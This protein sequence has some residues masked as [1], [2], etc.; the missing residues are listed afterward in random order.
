VNG[1]GFADLLLRQDVFLGRSRIDED[2]GRT[3]PLI[4]E[5]DAACVP[6]PK[7]RY[8]PSEILRCANM[9]Q[10]VA[11]GDVDADGYDD[12]V[13]YVDHDCVLFFRGSSQP[14]SP[15]KATKRICLE[16]LGRTPEIVRFGD[17]NGDG[18][19]DVGLSVGDGLGVFLSAPDGIPTRPSVVLPKAEAWASGGDFD[20]D[21]YDD[22]AAL[23]SDGRI[24]FFRGS[25]AGLSRDPAS[26]T[27]STDWQPVTDWTTPQIRL[28]DLDGDGLADLVGVRM[29]NARPV[30]WMISGVAA[31]TQPKRGASRAWP[32][33]DKNELNFRWDLFA[34]VGRSSDGVVMVV[35]RGMMAG[36]VNAAPFK[37]GMG[38]VLPTPPARFEDEVSTGRVPKAVGDVNGDG[39][40]DMFAIMTEDMDGSQDGQLF[41]GDASGISTRKGSYVWPYEGRARDG[42]TVSFLPLYKARR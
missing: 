38:F 4:P 5:D 33:W 3:L 8:P 32:W 28:G 27:P 18:L 26:Q 41:L 42:L 30:L 39:L 19:A 34:G 15:W 13:S 11:I 14:P 17:V 2:D 16:S 35:D 25:P 10:I 29:D 37:R 36:E 7:D 40:E 22:A 1:D 6:T 23:Q 12:I 21:G 24:L 31:F 9:G 20:G